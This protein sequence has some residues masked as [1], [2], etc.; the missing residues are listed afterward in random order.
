MKKVLVVED[1]QDNLKLISYALKRAGY[2]LVSATCGE[3]GLELAQAEP[4]DL[5]LMDINLPGI[6]GLETTRR[7]RDSEIDGRLPIIAITSF[8][9]VGDRERI[10]AAGCNGYIE[11]PIDP[12]AIVDQIHSI[13]ERWDHE[14]TDRR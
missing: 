10:L 4:L 9:M 14:N 12:L 5:I 2:E 7:I 11:K 8:A 13:I 1:N 6:D 3:D